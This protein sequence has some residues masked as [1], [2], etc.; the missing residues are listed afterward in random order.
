MI[1]KTAPQQPVIIYHATYSREN[2]SWSQSLYRPL[3][4]ERVWM[5]S[6]AYDWDISQVHFSLFGGRLVKQST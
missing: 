4:W 3:H 1:I 5:W 2:V 6:A